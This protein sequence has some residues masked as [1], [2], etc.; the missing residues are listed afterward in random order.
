VNHKA[1]IVP[2][3]SQRAKWSKTIPLSI[4]LRKIR[5]GINIEKLA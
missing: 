5:K 1:E 3:N 2:E 4:I